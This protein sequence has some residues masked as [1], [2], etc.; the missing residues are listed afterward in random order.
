MSIVTS[1]FPKPNYG[2]YISLIGTVSI[3]LWLGIFKFTPTEAVA[4][5]PLV[6]NHPLTSWVYGKMND[7]TISNL[8]GIFEIVVAILILVGLKYKI[9]AKI[10][11]ISVIIIFLMTISYLFTTPNTWRNVDN[12]LITDF[13]IFKDIMY[14]GFGVSFFQYA[15]N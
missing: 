1:T 12:I 5:K 6:S 8:I 3:L 7:Q 15:N 4:I 2:L 14:L 13:F 11:A 10:A 9:I